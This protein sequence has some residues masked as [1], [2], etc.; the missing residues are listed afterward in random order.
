MKLDWSEPALESLQ[1]IK[2]FIAFD[3]KYYWLCA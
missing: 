3:S 1:A 2:D